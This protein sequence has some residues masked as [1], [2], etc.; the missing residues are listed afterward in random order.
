MLQG[1]RSNA[2]QDGWTGRGRHGDG[3]NGHQGGHHGGNGN[4]HGHGGW[5]GGG[6]DGGSGGG[7]GGSDPYEGL[8]VIDVQGVIDVPVPFLDEDVQTGDPFR[9]TIAIP[10]DETAVT[11]DGEGYS[12]YFDTQPNSFLM[13]AQVGDTEIEHLVQAFV[14]PDDGT[15]LV[16]GDD[17]T[18]REFPV[19]PEPPRV[20]EDFFIADAPGTSV[21]PANNQ[22]VYLRGRVYLS[23]PSGAMIDGIDLQRE[24]TYVPPEDSESFVQF[25]R[26]RDGPELFD[27]D[28]IGTPTSVSINGINPADVF[29]ASNLSLLGYPADTGAGNGCFA[30]F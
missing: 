19:V 30:V 12:R 11:S 20:P 16:I 18:Y 6:N 5:N 4:H 7:N 29:S 3:G 21:D 22:E 17:T 14:A 9:L 23:D 27:A 26:F 15:R 24:T 1:Y 10:Y 25:S 13:S 28:I 8:Y 2:G